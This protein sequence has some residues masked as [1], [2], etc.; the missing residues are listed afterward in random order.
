MVA[1]GIGSFAINNLSTEL[2]AYS[3]NQDI[4]NVAVRVN[5]T[6]TQ[7]EHY[8]LQLELANL[9]QTYKQLDADI[10]AK[11]KPQLTNL[12]DQLVRRHHLLNQTKR[13]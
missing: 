11:V 4:T 10:Q 9:A 6:V 7:A 8:Q 3:L 5:S 1:V 12:K 13:I 2:H